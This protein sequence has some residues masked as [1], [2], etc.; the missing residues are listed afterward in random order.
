MLLFAFSI[1]RVGRSVEILREEVGEQGT[2]GDSDN[3]H[4]TSDDIKDEV[5]LNEE[6]GNNSEGD[7]DTKSR[8]SNCIV[9]CNALPCPNEDEILDR[10][11][12]GAAEMIQKDTSTKT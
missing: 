1:R 7:D 4:D 6:L 9:K 11:N 12:F 10:R 2:Q 8:S 3:G 5:E